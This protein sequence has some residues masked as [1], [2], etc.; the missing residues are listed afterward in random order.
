MMRGDSDWGTITENAVRSTAWLEGAGLFNSFEYKGI[1]IKNRRFNSGRAGLISLLEEHPEGIVIYRSGIHAMVL[2]DYTDGIF[3]LADTG[4]FGPAYTRF[5]ETQMAQNAN[6][7]LTI[8][9]VDQIWYVESPDVSIVSNDLTVSAGYST[10][11]T[12]FSWNQVENADYYNLRIWKDK[13]W[14]GDDFKTEWD[15]KDTKCDLKLPSGTY[16]AYVDVVYPDD[17]YKMTNVVEFKV[18][19]GTLLYFEQGNSSAETVFSWNS[20]DGA[21]SYDL[22][23]WKDHKV[24]DG[25]AYHIEWGITGTE[26]STVLPA[27]KYEAYLDTTKNEEYVKMSNI[28]SF[29]IKNGSKLSVETGT[30]NQATSFEWNSIPNAKSFNL[31]IWKDKL[32]DGDS[33]FEKSNLTELSYDVLLPKGYY[34]AYVD[35]IFDDDTYNMSNVIKFTIEK[36]SLKGDCNND[37]TISAA[38]IVALKKWLLNIEGAEINIDTAD[39]NQNGS[40]DILDFIMLKAHFL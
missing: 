22:K 8:D 32:W 21:S 35:S 18:E 31:K 12:E 36:N 9:N 37:G 13:L 33:Y 2:T 16:F 40:V 26:F 17:S 38:D 4:G 29:E 24:W 39:F 14:E 25:E 6:S 10:S 15:C 28:I 1:V 34:E 30:E 11:N 23:I 20:V 3:Y 5:P 27:G 19:D 7:G